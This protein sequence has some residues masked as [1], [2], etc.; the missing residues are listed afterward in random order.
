ML[1]KKMLSRLLFCSGRFAAAALF[2]LAEL[3]CAAGRSLS[4]EPTAETLASAQ[5][6]NAPLEDYAALLASA[7][8]H[9]TPQTEVKCPGPKKQYNP[10]LQQ[11][12]ARQHCICAPLRAGV[13]T[14]Q[15]SLPAAAKPALVCV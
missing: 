6:Q 9:K 15:E 1:Y 13:A 11:Q 10:R 8:P 14:A 3:G 4:A 5:Q 2:I 12:K 7:H